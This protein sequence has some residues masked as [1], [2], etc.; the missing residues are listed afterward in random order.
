MGKY[1]SRNS[2][3]ELHKRQESK[4][5]DPTPKIQTCS[6]RWALQNQR[7][8]EVRWEPRDKRMSIQ[9]AFGVMYVRSSYWKFKKRFKAYEK[10]LGWNGHVFG[11][12]EYVF[13]P[14]DQPAVLMFLATMGA[15]RTCRIL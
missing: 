10:T 15:P 9:W 14:F 12:E 4:Q 11:M 1:H 5:K 7:G 6:L 13:E 8:C 2:L 3:E